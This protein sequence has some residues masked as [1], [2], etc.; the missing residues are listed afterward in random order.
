MEKDWWIVR[1]SSFFLPS[2]LSVVNDNVPTSVSQKR[3]QSY[4]SFFFG[5]NHNNKTYNKHRE[6]EFVPKSQ[7]LRYHQLCSPDKMV[8]E[9]Y[10]RTQGGSPSW[11]GISSRPFS[12][13]PKSN[14]MK[15]VTHN[16]DD[17]SVDP[18]SPSIR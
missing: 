15:N 1:V 18:S 6:L 5:T 10:K 9:K 3:N 11:S 16:R 4:Q 2:V 12:Y 17:G 13:V 7:G 8:F 14:Q